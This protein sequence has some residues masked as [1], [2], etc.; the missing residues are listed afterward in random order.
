MPWR[1][2]RDCPVQ[3]LQTLVPGPAST[4][5]RKRARRFP[6]SRTDLIRCLGSSSRELADL[7]GH[8]FTARRDPGGWE[9]ATGAFHVW[10]YDRSSAEAIP[11][12]HA[13]ASGRGNPSGASSVISL[14]A[15]MSHWEAQ[16]GA[17]ACGKRQRRDGAGGIFPIARPRGGGS[18]S[19]LRLAVYLGDD[20]LL[21]WTHHGAHRSGIRPP[22]RTPIRFWR[23]DRRRSWSRSGGHELVYCG[24]PDPRW[25][26]RRAAT[27]S[28]RTTR[29]TRTRIPFLPSSLGKLGV[30]REGHRLIHS[31]VTGSSTGASYR[32]LPN[33]ATE[34]RPCLRRRWSKAMQRVVNVD[35][36]P[37]PRCQSRV[38]AVKSPDDVPSTAPPRS[39]RRARL[40]SSRR[41]GGER[42]GCRRVDTNVG[43]AER[44]SPSRGACACRSRRRVG[45][46]SASAKKS[47]TSLDCA[48]AM[49]VLWSS[50]RTMR[51]RR[52]TYRDVLAVREDVAPSGR[53]HRWQLSEGGERRAGGHP[54]PQPSTK[55]CASLHGTS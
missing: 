28:S 50:A 10:A 34:V 8:G 15:I 7:R 33:M 44:S 35:G 39:A 22:F 32:W 20:K 24:R 54:L 43:A 52:A 18:R 40:R 45:A 13:V 5:T 4:T 51:H 14:G 55:S 31:R 42:D 9:P 27:A 38:H 1:S 47:V 53:R 26:Q 11:L 41:R 36:G 49:T 25:A 17:I 48:C 16:S 37:P 19:S 29:S 23:A 21:E 6:G 3:L 12:P 30:D 2:W 46:R